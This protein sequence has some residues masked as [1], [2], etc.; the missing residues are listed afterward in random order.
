MLCSAVLGRQASGPSEKRTCFD[1]SAQCRPCLKQ[2]QCARARLPRA[3]RARPRVPARVQTR[4]SVDP[5]RTK[6]CLVP[7]LGLH[8]QIWNISCPLQTLAAAEWKGK[9]NERNK[10]VLSTSCR[11]QPHLASRALFQGHCAAEKARRDGGEQGGQWGRNRLTKANGGPKSPPCT[12]PS[13]S[14]PL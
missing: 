8:R 4:C 12:A 11:L 6:P 10:T 5:A 2:T 3:P 9:L 7:P 1:L 14:P 13:P